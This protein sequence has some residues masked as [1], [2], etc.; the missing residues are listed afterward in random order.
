VNDNHRIAL[1]RSYAKLGNESQVIVYPGSFYELPEKNQIIRDR[2]RRQWGFIKGE[3]VIGA[4]GGFNMTSGADW[5]LKTMKNTQD[6][7]AVIQPL[8]V[9]QLAL[10]LLGELEFIDRMFIQ[11]ERLSWKD[12]WLTAQGFDLGLCIYSNPASQFQKMGISSNRLCMFL[13]MGVPV[14]A[15]RQESFNFLED[16]ECGIMVSS[17]DEFRIAVDTIRS[18]HQKMKDN[19]EKCFRDYIQPN[20]YFQRL[21]SF[22]HTLGRQ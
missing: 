9:S 5:L 11:N 16:Y 13:A 4:S 18:N 20:N 3:F 2:I 1:L 10:Y 8:G 17:Y 21:K 22:I 19:C 6:L 7:F 15:S 12:A 14:I